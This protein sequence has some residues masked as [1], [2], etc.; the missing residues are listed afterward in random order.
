M[1]RGDCQSAPRHLRVVR[2]LANGMAMM[3]THARIRF[4]Y[5]IYMTAMSLVVDIIFLVMYYVHRGAPSLSRS[6]AP[7]TSPSPRRLVRVVVV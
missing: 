5:V 7:D 2:P 4:D 3:F 1:C 6:D